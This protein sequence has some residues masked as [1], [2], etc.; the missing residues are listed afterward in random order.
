MTALPPIRRSSALLLW[1]IAG[2]DHATISRGM[3]ADDAETKNGATPGN[4]HARDVLKKA[5]AKKSRR[6]E[7]DTTT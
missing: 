3:Q 5:Q 4:T 6:Y 2:N 1:K 7:G